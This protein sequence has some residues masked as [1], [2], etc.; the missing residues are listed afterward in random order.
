MCREDEWSDEW[1]DAW[2]DSWEERS[3]GWN[4]MLVER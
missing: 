2:T 1:M 3:D 4:D